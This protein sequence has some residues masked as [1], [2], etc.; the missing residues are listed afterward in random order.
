MTTQQ[1]D[2]RTFLARSGSAA[3]G[4]GGA[5]GWVA[6]DR[7]D[8]HGRHDRIPVHVGYATTRAYRAATGAASRT[9]R[10]HAF[11]AVT[12]RLDAAEID[13]LRRHPGVRYVERVRPVVAL[14]ERRTPVDAGEGTGARDEN[15]ADPLSGGIDRVDA[16]L[17]HEEATGE[18]VDVAVVDTGVADGHQALA[19]ALADGEAVVRAGLLHFPG[20]DDDDGHGTHC[21]GTVAARSAAGDG[22]APDAT[23]HAVKVLNGRGVGTTDDVAVGIERV[24]ARGWDV[25]CLAFGTDESALLSDA[26]DHAAEAGVSLVAAVGT[27]GPTAPASHDAC[28]AVG[29][30]APD[31]TPAAF[32]PSGV[33][34]LLA[35][36]VDVRSTVPGGY[37]RIS[38]S[39]MACAHAVGAL[40]LLRGDGYDAP[41]AR[42]RLLDTAEDLGLDTSAQGA[43]LLDVAAALGVASDDD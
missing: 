16:E 43:G 3:V 8:R 24:A 33:V 6:P 13:R 30:A 20:W 4:L 15:T 14:G 17:V 35:P 42:E 26:V 38:G 12:V 28:L 11:D 41:S 32:T 21:A 1:L 7:N 31:G 22:V 27:R 19:H 36:G 29:G 40:A 18:G 10:D 5:G 9:L 2:R 23:L 39:S 37:D 25:A 34:D